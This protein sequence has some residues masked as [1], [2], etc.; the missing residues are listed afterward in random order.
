MVQFELKRLQTDFP[1][2]KVTSEKDA[3]Q[4]IRKFYGDDIE[5]F[6]S[7]FILLLNQANLTIGYAKISQGGITGTVV[8]TRLVAKYAIESLATGV[9]LAH[10]HPSGNLM[11]SQADRAI[12]EKLKRGLAIFDIT[13]IDSLILTKGGYAKV[14]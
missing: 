13:L 3:E 14:D 7:C 5:I 6:E 11:S 4:V 10:N 2:V 9:I 1:A 12:T 8:D